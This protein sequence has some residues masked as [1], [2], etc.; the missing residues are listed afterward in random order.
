MAI[1]GDDTAFHAVSG[2]AMVPV[3]VLSSVRA[4]EACFA[5]GEIVLYVEIVDTSTRR[6]VVAFPLAFMSRF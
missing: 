6:P 3:A 1:N 5:H 2:Y 4:I